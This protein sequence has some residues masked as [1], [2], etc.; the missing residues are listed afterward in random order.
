MQFYLIWSSLVILTYSEQVYLGLET[1]KHI[2][3]TT[4]ATAALAK[5][6]G[7]YWSGAKHDR[8]VILR[9]TLGPSHRSAT[10]ARLVNATRT[11]LEVQD[12]KT[13]THAARRTPTM[14]SCSFSTCN[15]PISD[16]QR[17]ASVRYSTSYIHPSKLV[18]ALPSNLGSS[19][20][21]YSTRMYTPVTQSLDCPSRKPTLVHVIVLVIKRHPRGSAAR[22]IRLS[23]TNRNCKISRAM[24]TTI[25]PSDATLSQTLSK[26]MPAPVP[27]LRAQKTQIRAITYVTVIRHDNIFNNSSSWN[28]LF[29]IVRNPLAQITQ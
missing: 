8:I 27:A 11:Q 22:N 10:A 12:S 19:A 1:P 15:G 4:C 16:N 17:S 29:M 21:R 20:V 7:D 13:A 18:V 26:A 28:T 24:S 5:Q 3:I 14:P 9:G 25:D 2:S 6:F 23:P